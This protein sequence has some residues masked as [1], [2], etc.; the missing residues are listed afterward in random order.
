[1]CNA[2][3]H[4]EAR[5]PSRFY[6]RPFN[7]MSVDFSADDRPPLASPLPGLASCIMIYHL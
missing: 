4:Y 5:H 7:F 3:N 1:M 6:K 2:T